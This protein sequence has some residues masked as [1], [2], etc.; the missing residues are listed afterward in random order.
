MILNYFHPRSLQQ[1]YNTL[2]RAKKMKYLFRWTHFSESKVKASRA[3]LTIFTG[4]YLY[5]TQQLSAEELMVF[6]SSLEKLLVTFLHNLL[7]ASRKKP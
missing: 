6:I 2:S 4:Q 5:V 7:R 1:C 3:A